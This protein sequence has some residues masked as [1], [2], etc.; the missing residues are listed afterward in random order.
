MNAV[1]KSAA[2]MCVCLGAADPLYGHIVRPLGSANVV[3]KRL[4]QPSHLGPLNSNANDG[5]GTIGRATG[6]VIL[7]AVT[8][9]MVA[10]AVF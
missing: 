8:Y 2:R 5:S 3:C 1:G 9:L 4:V 7:R 10:T 6:S